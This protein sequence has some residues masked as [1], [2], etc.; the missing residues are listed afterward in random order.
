MTDIPIGRITTT[1]EITN[2]LDQ[3]LAAKGFIPLEQVRTTTLHDVSVNTRTTLL[4]LTQDI[5]AQLG[6]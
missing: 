2:R 5:I 3:V 4:C 6:L 1:L